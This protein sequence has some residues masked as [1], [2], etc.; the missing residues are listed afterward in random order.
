MSEDGHPG[1]IRENGEQADV[2]PQTHTHT[3]M[4][5]CARREPFAT[6]VIDSSHKTLRVAASIRVFL[7]ATIQ[8]CPQ[9]RRVCVFPCDD[10][11]FW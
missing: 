4:C 5:T 6:G 8:L 10:F 9:H 3:H 1:A 7:I 2:S 11:N